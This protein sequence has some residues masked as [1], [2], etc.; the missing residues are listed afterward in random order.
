MAIFPHQMCLVMHAGHS[1]SQMDFDPMVLEKEFPLIQ[2]HA[3]EEL[4]G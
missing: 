1:P 3:A 2:A 4:G